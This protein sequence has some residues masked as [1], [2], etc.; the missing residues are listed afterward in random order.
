V[1]WILANGIPSAIGVILALGHPL[2]VLSAFLAAPITSL[3]PVIGAGYVAAF[4]QLFVSPPIVKD[5]ESASN[6]VAK[7]KKWWTN[8]L[9]R[10]LLVFIFSGLGS[11]IGTYVGAYE[12]IKN[13][14]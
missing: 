1:F 11:A 6:E 8:R 3:T 13:I 10:I 2:T 5:F 14:F 4:V 9:L 12:I 7:F